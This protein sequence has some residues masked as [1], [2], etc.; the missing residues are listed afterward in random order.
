MNK[1]NGLILLVQSVT[2][3]VIIDLKHLFLLNCVKFKLVNDNGYIVSVSRDMYEW[4]CITGYIGYVSF[5]QQ[6]LYFNER[7][8]RYIRIQCEER[9]RY[10][11]FQ[12]TML[13]QR[14]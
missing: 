9:Y 7:D 4:K 11:P 10:F 13:Y 8:V 14:N 1:H 3:C 12:N 2:D 5:G 6:V